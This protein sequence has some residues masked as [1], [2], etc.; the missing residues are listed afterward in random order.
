MLATPIRDQADQIVIIALVQNPALHHV[1]R[2][3]EIFGC[4][5]EVLP[6]GWWF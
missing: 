4:K 1:Y 5:T 2:D 3:S 6:T